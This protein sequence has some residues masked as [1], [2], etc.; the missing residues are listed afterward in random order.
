MCE[1]SLLKEEKELFENKRT[2]SI[3]KPKN[4]WKDLKLLGLSSK[5]G[6]DV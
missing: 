1:I 4:L 2:E 3:D 6:G 5:S